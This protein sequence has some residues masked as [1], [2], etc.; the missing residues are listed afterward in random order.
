[1]IE[2]CEM[3][4][5]EGVTVK[6]SHLSV[7]NVEFGPNRNCG[8]ESTIPER[9]YSWLQKI[10]GLKIYGFK[11]YWLQQILSIDTISHN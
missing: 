6:I 11:I 2:I 7:W 4:P 8:H 3:S 1:M 5:P 9:E 10:Y